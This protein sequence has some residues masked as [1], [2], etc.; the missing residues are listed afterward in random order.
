MAC[1]VAAI[2][3]QSWKREIQQLTS[4]YT[5]TLKTLKIVK[6]ELELSRKKNLNSD[7][8]KIDD[9][10]IFPEDLTYDLNQESAVLGRGAFGLVIRGRYRGQPVA[11]KILLKRDE[12]SLKH[13]QD[14][15]LLMFKLRHPNIVHLVGILFRSEYPCI[16]ME[17]AALGNMRHVLRN[18]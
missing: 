15:A 18:R 1:V 8:D 13:L 16:I 2:V 17:Y 6:N 7:A 10:R 14:E 12:A 3:L 5:K 4:K 9:L 11:I